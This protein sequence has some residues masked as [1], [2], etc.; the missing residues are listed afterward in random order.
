MIHENENNDCE[1]V[2]IR[3][4]SSENCLKNF[5]FPLSLAS[6]PQSNTQNACAH[7]TL[8]L[9]DIIGWSTTYTKQTHEIKS[10]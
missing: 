8:L 6:Q 4:K 9:Y 5:I 1:F 7:N 3:K 10:N 2:C